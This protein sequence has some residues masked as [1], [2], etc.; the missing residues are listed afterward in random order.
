MIDRRGPFGQIERTHL[1]QDV[2]P[3][4]Q[5]ERGG[6]R[7]DEGQGNQGVDNR[8]VGFERQLAVRVVGIHRVILLGNNHMLRG[9]H[10]LIAERFGLLDKRNHHCR[11]GEFTQVNRDDTEFHTPSLTEAF[12]L[13]VFSIAPVEPR[14]ANDG[15]PSC[16]VGPLLPADDSE[17]S[18]RTTHSR[19]APSTRSHSVLGHNTSP[20]GG[21]TYPYPLTGR[22]P[23][24]GATP[25]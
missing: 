16:G 22:S 6:G 5:P 23:F 12:T 11:V 4:A 1:G 13:F 15:L 3:G 18:N 17:P 20:D 21:R 7:G 14:T 2:D 25:G 24:P 10:G 19:C 8:R 9:P